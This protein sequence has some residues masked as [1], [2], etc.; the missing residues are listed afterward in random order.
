MALC[1]REKI[2][3][4]SEKYEV[5]D[6]Q[7]KV[8]YS[9]K[10]EV[11]SFGHKIHIYNAQGEE[12]AFIREKIWTFFKKFE[13]SLHGEVKGLV[14]EKF[15]WFHPRY[16]VDFMNCQVTG[17]IFAWNYEIKRGE[18]PVAL[19]QRKIFSWANVF[20][21]TYPDPDDELAVLALAIAIDAAH[22][23]DEAAEIAY[24]STI[25]Y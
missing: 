24:A 1:I 13:I 12:V 21:L 7:Q 11:F 8:L 15:S 6:E 16:E 4:W 22:N 19:V 18:E 9:V 14:K 3:S 17:D 23:D 25:H 5:Y 2:F 20:Y 10:G